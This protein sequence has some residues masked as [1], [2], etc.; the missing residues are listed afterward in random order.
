MT[1]SK[2]FSKEEKAMVIIVVILAAYLIFMLYPRFISSPSVPGVET[3]DVEIIKISG[4]EDCFNIEDS[5]TLIKGVQGV[6]VENERII[7]RDSDEAR[8]LISKFGFTRFP[9]MVVYSDD[10]DKI[11]V[12]ETVFTK[13]DDAIVF[14][15][16][17]PYV[18]VDSDEVKGLIDMKE[19]I[20]GTCSECGSLSKM[21][22][23]FESLGVMVGN[24]EIIDS[25]SEAGKGLISGNE[26][27]M[28]PSLLLSKDIDEYWWLTEVLT[29]VIDDSSDEYY[30]F[31][32]PIYP[33]KEILTGKIIGKV[34]I[35][36]LQN[37]SCED[38]FNITELKSG[39]QRIGVFIDGENYVEVSSSAGKSLISKY[40][41]TIIPTVVLSKELGD[42][43]LIEKSLDQVGTFESDGKFVFRGIDGLGVKY[44]TI[45]GNNGN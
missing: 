10:L 23:Q 8:E 28:I 40:N 11:A 38:C 30:T 26:L 9:V 43:D 31:K 5:S 22:E 41:I 25:K 29:S 34:D 2:K 12:D 17:V 1:K 6:V 20:D 45:G 4:C 32:N 27:K 44:Q 35:T 33:H 14:D 15:R 3:Y 37:S 18:E 19:I 21:R 36:Y 16:P 24:Y 7:S 13:S 39:F 42:Y